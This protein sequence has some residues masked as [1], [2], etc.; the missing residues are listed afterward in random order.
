MIA[1]ARLKRRTKLEML[2]PE[3]QEEILAHCKNLTQKEGAQWLKE[4]HGIE[5]GMTSLGK[6][7]TEKQERRS[8]LKP[9]RKTR[10][11]SRL[12]ILPADAQENIFSHCETVT[13]EEGVK[14]LREEMK[15]ESS[16]QGLSRW[17]MK[18][19]ADMSMEERL[20]EIRD[21]SKRA[22]MVG[23]LFGAATALSE[24]NC[25]LVA[26][27]VFEE[28]R[29]PAAERDSKRLMQYMGMALKA[30]TVD[31]AYNKFRFDAAKRAR[32]CA[33]GLN[34]INANDGDER[35]KTEM[36]MVLL[37]GEAPSIDVTLPENNPGE[38]DVEPTQEDAA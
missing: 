2:A 19:R 22:K 3:L 30:R 14:W 35:K 8:I 11:D 4:E 25:V 18:R 5:A 34:E 31:L 16:A 29:R 15:I 9:A 26:Q 38:P 13:L 12:G 23:D 36:A 33:A 21:D 10:A 27:A 28:F 32:E 6:W 17:L 20:E 37:F 24:A 7:L 1:K